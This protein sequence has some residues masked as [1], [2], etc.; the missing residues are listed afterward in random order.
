MHADFCTNL[1]SLSAL[2]SVAFALFFQN[3]F[4]PSS[5]SPNP[6]SPPPLPSFP[7]MSPAFL[8]NHYYYY[9]FMFLLSEECSVIL[10]VLLCFFPLQIR[11]VNAFRMGL[12]ADS[13]DKRSLSSLHSQHSLQNLR[14]QALKKSVSHDAEAALN[15]PLSVTAMQQQSSDSRV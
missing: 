4:P 12:E 6:L 5:R 13:F 14:L 11:V 10:L 3:P 7:P 15:R 8:S 2:L 1:F 9:V